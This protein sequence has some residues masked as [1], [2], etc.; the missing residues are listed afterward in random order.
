MAIRPL[1]YVPTSNVALLHKAQAGTV[2]RPDAGRGLRKGKGGGGALTDNIGGT[3]SLQ[4]EYAR[5]SRLF[6]TYKYDIDVF[7][8]VRQV[9]RRMPPW[10][11]EETVPGAGTEANKVLLDSFFHLPD[12]ENTCQQIVRCTIARMKMVGKAHWALRR[13]DDQALRAAAP[14]SEGALALQH[15]IV[16]ALSKQFDLNL[17]DANAA[18]QDLLGSR[19]PIGFE[20]LAGALRYDKQRRV[21]QQSTGGVG[22]GKEFAAEDVLEFKIMDPTGGVMSELERL[23]SWSDASVRVFKL[24][25]DAVKTGGMADLLIVLYGSN[26]REV[27]RLEALM[28]DR[29]DPARTEDVWL[30]MV[31]HSTAPEGQRVGVEQ[32]ELSRRGRE[33]M[34]LEF[35]KALRVRKAGATGVPLQAVG[36]WQ[37]VN[38]ANMETADYILMQHE[39]MPW[40][41]DFRGQVNEQLVVDVFGITDWEFGFDEVDLRGQEFA[42]EQDQDLLKTG[43]LTPYDYWVKTHGGAR[44]EAMLAAVVALGIDEAA[45]KIPWQFTGNKWAPITEQIPPALGGPEPPKPP[46][47][48]LPFGATTAVNPA[49]ASTNPAEG[50]AAPPAEGGTPPAPGGM[51]PPNVPAANADAMMKSLDHWQE[52]CTVSMR[53]SGLVYCP[54]ADAAAWRVLPQQMYLSLGKSLNSC[55]SVVE[56]SN[57]FKDARGVLRVASDK[58]EKVKTPQHVMRSMTDAINEVFMARDQHAQLAVAERLRQE[59]EGF[60]T[61]AATVPAPPLKKA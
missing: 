1:T 37:Q 10:R 47:P 21:W 29:A 31:T 40:C 14:G 25:A 44:A 57:T 7:A 32:V 2:T 4:S 18:V 24:N 59:A 17:A 19:A 26:K 16:N 61:E 27:E 12:G 54:E 55:T 22:A 20:L 60:E 5:I 3:M 9:M 49:N 41:E 6:N 46:A 28:E 38:R 43:A 33:S 42:H 34:H 36:E 56:I 50:N 45:V 11:L 39:I 53:K 15:N 23:E 35:D 13:L 52:E 48:V 58:L 30:P 51:M 8:M